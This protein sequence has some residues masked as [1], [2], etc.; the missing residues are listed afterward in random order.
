[1]LISKHY[2]L[3]QT[4]F[5]SFRTFRLTSGEE[6]NLSSSGSSFLNYKL[7]KRKLMYDL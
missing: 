4:F 1:M 7:S 3:V 5:A 6:K 2:Y